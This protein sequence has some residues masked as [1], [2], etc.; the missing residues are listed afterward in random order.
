VVKRKISL[1]D[2][3][4]KL[5]AVDANNELYQF[6]SLIRMRDGTPLKDKKGNITSHLA[7]LLFR[8][9]R[10]IHDYGILPVFVFDGKPPELKQTTIQQ[11]RQQREKA[12]REW[13]E[14]LGRK[15]YASAWSKA[16]MMSRLTPSMVEDAKHTLQLLGIPLVQ[17]PGE[18]EA[19]A[20]H[21][22]SRGD[23][24]ASNS[25][26]YDS[27]LFGTSRLVRYVTISGT[28]FLPSKGYARPLV[29][30]LIEQT[31]LL[32]TLGISREQLVDLAIL[33]GTDFN[34]GIKGIGPKTALRLVREY[35]SLEKL[36]SE[37]TSRLPEDY[38]K[39]RRIFLEPEITD[40][41]SIEFAPMNEQGLRSFLCEERSFSAERVATV[42]ER[43]RA[44]N[45]QLRQTKFAK[46]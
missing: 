12:E 37:V 15:D 30:E 21:M 41:Y 24:W 11:R 17:A 9:T 38:Q 45:Q 4:G 44:F 29:P 46:S 16:V 42:V 34:H 18:G 2:L 19:Q 5:L 14:A 20:A 13:K 22:A 43:M 40:E 6:L 26:D 8:T 28:E 33:V 10:L 31:K 25:R 1:G 3:R 27:L 35:G 39:V 32:E 23:A 36:P 7:G